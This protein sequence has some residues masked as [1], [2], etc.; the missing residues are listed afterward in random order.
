MAKQ[1]VTFHCYINDYIAVV[2]KARADIAF[3]H[4]CMLLQEL[5]LPLNSD[6][7]TPPTNCLTCLGIEVDT[8]ANVLRIVPDKL[9]EI[10][11]EVSQKMHLSK[12]QYQS[13][14]GKLFYI[15]RNVSNRLTYS[16]TGFLLI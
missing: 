12:R 6:K 11:L 4:L 1:D 5:G 7:F 13:L 8:G 3:Q 16:L 14:L 10:H 9:H 15:Y 2:P